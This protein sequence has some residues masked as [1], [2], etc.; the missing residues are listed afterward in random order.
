MC[1]VETG[2]GR[3]LMASNARKSA[4]GHTHPGRRYVLDAHKEATDAAKANA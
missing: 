1:E 3:G 2:K 4:A